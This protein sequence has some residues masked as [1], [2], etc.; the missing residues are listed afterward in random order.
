MG[1]PQKEKKKFLGY[2]FF[3]EQTKKEKESNCPTEEMETPLYD[4][5]GTDISAYTELDDEEFIKLIPRGPFPDAM[6]K[7]RITPLAAL[8]MNDRDAK[9]A[10]LIRSHKLHWI[11]LNAF[12][13]NECVNY[14][15]LALCHGAYESAVALVQQLKH[16][17]FVIEDQASDLISG[18]QMAQT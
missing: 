1:I 14:L 17:E 18:R 12:V 10:Y 2:F 6:D 9:A 15:T 4:F 13:K 3:S 5:H 7:M 11:A 8:I 16:G